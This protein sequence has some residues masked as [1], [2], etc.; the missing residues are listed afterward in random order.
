MQ[1]VE[2]IFQKDM[3][4]VLLSV[5]SKYIRRKLF[6]EL[7]Y[8]RRSLRYVYIYIYIYK[9]FHIANSVPTGEN[10]LNYYARYIQL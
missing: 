8:E 1:A 2:C 10:V 6:R 9:Q 3:S 4:R 7:K 5:M